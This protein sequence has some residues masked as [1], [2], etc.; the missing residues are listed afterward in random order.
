[1][2]IRKYPYTHAFVRQLIYN[3]KY[4]NLSLDECGKMALERQSKITIDVPDYL[5]NGLKTAMSTYNVDA[6]EIILIAL[7]KFLSKKGIVK[8][9]EMDE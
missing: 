3:S 7:D 5:E 6:D 8:G 1:M 4:T 2:S 9:L